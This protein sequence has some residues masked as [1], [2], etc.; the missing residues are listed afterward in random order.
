MVHHP[1]DDFP[2]R[3]KEA[4]DAII[5]TAFGDEDSDN[6]PKLEGYLTFIPDGLDEPS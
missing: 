4:N 1:F 6:P 5:P 3:L 2:Y